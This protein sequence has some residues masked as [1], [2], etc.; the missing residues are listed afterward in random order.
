VVDLDAPK[1]AHGDCEDARGD[2]K[3]EE[4]KRPVR[5]KQAKGE[6]SEEDERKRIPP[7]VE[8]G[9]RFRAPSENEE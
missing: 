3:H 4:T 6:A 7:D 1:K 9:K 5:D 2:G 8:Q